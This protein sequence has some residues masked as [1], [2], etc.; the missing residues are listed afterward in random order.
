MISHINIMWPLLK[1]RKL[2][3]R[4]FEW[5]AS[6][7]N[8]KPMVSNKNKSISWMDFIKQR[9]SILLDI[10]LTLVIY[11]NLNMFHREF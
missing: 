11:V 5:F 1:G 4:S 7:N 9:K 2:S 6:E 8:R 3:R 10:N